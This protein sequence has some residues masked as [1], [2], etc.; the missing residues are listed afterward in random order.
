MA[1]TFT[2]GQI[3]HALR[4]HEQSARSYLHEVNQ[5]IRPGY[6]NYGEH[7]DVQTIYLLWRQHQNSSVGRRLVPL[8]QTG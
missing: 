3:A 7:V 4:C 5:R 6:S 1:R 8:L 2:V